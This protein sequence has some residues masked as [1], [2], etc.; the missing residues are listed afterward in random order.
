VASGAEI[1]IEE[2]DPREVTHIG[3]RRIAPE[4]VQVANPA[5]DVTPH[6]YVTAIITENGVAR[7]PFSEALQRLVRGIGDGR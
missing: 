4:G 5:F 1:V 2:R 6:R 3:G 7:E